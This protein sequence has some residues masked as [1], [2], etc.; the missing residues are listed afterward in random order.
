MAKEDKEPQEPRA[1]RLVRRSSSV[2]LSVRGGN[3]DALKACVLLPPK[4]TLVLM[5]GGR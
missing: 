3:H 5:P 1:P 4:A 2:N